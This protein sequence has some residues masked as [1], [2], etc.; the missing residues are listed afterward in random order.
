MVL[1]GGRLVNNDLTSKL[2]IKIMIKT[3]KLM[4]QC[5]MHN[6]V[7][8]SYFYRYNVSIII[9]QPNCNESRVFNI[10]NQILS[11]FFSLKFF[12]LF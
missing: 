10:M 5:G 9:L 2:A 12:I 3:A 7:T 6:F 11:R 1:L 8:L 4:S